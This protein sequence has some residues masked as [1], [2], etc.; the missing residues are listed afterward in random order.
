MESGFSVSRMT[1]HID[2]KIDFSDHNLNFLNLGIPYIC[3][4]ES[5]KTEFPIMGKKYFY[6]PKECAILDHSNSQTQI[7]IEGKSHGTI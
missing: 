2:N 1:S 5:E 7:V 3:L 6:V 4:A